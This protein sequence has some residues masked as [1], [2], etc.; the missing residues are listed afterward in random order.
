MVFKKLKPLKKEEIFVV[1]IR[2]FKN[3]TPRLIANMKTKICSGEINFITKDGDKIFL[4]MKRKV[5]L[6]MEYI[7]YNIIPALTLQTFENMA[8]KE[9]DADWRYFNLTP[10]H[11]ETYQRHGRNYWPLVKSMPGYI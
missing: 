2:G 11:D 10:R 6:K 1:Q 5:F 9:P 3:P 8:R 4:S 7:E